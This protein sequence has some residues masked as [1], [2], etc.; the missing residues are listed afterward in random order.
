MTVSA[1]KTF[2]GNGHGYVYKSSE[3][4]GD[5]MHEKEHPKNVWS[6]YKI[7]ERTACI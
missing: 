2:V 6:H 3:I 4:W 1:I 5:C 7:G